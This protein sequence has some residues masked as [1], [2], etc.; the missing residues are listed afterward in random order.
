MTTHSF[1]RTS[2]GHNVL[3]FSCPLHP[4]VVKE[5]LAYLEESELARQRQTSITKD[6]DVSS[7]LILQLQTDLHL[8]HGPVY[9]SRS[10]KGW[11]WSKSWM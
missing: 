1:P 11:V 4:D 2:L 7:A 8:V 9:R 5:D 3:L 10:A 6:L